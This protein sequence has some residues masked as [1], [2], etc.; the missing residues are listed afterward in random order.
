[1]ARYDSFIYM[2]ALIFSPTEDGWEK[3]K[4]FRKTDIPPPAL[5]GTPE[6]SQSAILRV[7]YAGVCGSDRGIFRREAFRDQILGSLAAEKKPYR[8]LGHEFFGEVVDVGKE[9]RRTFRIKPGDMVSCES[10]VVCGRCFQCRA[11]ESHVCT[12]E[13]ILGISHDGGF[14]EYVKVPAHIL[15]KT[16]VGKIR[17]EVAALQEPFGNA[18]HAASKVPLK[19][20]TVFISGLGPIGLFLVLITRSLGAKRVIGVDPNPEARDM[21]KAFGIDE[22]FASGAPSVP[23]G[24]HKESIEC[25]LAHTEGRGADVA[26]EMAG[27]NS[28]LNTALRATRRGG[29]V[30]LFGIKSGDF[31]LE[32]YHALIVRGVTMH[33]VIGRRLWDTWKM[34]QK[35]LENPKNRIQELLYTV[36]L[37]KGIGTIMDIAEYRNDLFEQKLKE[38]VKL[39]IKFA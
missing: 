10:H 15:W 27:Y 16:N 31:I 11:G 20:K 34:T 30:I 21:A 7:H 33:A 12:N 38:H 19:G 26:F 3:S 6:D 29:N 24:A 28:S 8:I 1:M 22:V 4:G 17:P 25:I 36:M 13:K 37:N 5:M 39:L 18:V 2:Q 9:A 35:L 32:D 14:A 23:H